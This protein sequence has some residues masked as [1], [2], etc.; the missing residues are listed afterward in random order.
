MKI[1]PRPHCLPVAVLVL[2]GCFTCVAKVAA[3]DF[4]QRI[5]VSRGT[6]LDARFYGGEVAVR[7]WNRDAVR[8]RATL[9]STDAIDIAVAGDVVTVRTRA[10]GG[11]P[12][13]IDVAIDVPAWMPVRVAGPYVDISV[14]G[15][16]ADVA[17]ETV[18][19]DVRVNGGA[20][21]IT[22]KSIEGDVI[23]EGGQGRADVRAANNDVRITGLKGDLFAE[24]VNGTVT[25]KNLQA[26]SVNVTTIA[27]DIAWDGDV[28]D[29]GRYRL[30]TH[31]GDIDLTLPEHDNATLSLRPFEGRLRS[32]MAVNVPGGTGR[33]PV[34]LVLGNGA[35]RLDV[36][37]FQGTISLRPAGG[38]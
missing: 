4:D 22:L 8:V 14:R 15:T 28:P 18:R 21:T 36:E 37:T 29:R 9:F 19:G 6:R 12:H 33:N 31:N 20:G 2:C 38:S 32:T 26:T 24:T 25:L 30:A 34:S 3:G 5:A 13:P 17:A 16:Q 27:G 7:G 1:V 35:A 10:L 23:L 11:R